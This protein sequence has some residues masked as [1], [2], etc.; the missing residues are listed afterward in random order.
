MLLDSTPTRNADSLG[1]IASEIE[2]CTRCP[3]LDAFLQESRAK[4]PDYWSRPVPGFG[5]P[6]ARLMMLGL[7]PGFHGA[8][9]HGR[10]FTGD[11]SGKWLFGALYD[12]GVS[13][14]PVSTGR[15]QPLRLD[16]VWISASA[17]CVPP[18]NKP[19]VEELETCRPFLA[20]ELALLPNLKVILALGRIGHDQ[21]L[22][23]LGLKLS[24]YPFAHGAVHELPEGPILMDTYHPSR[25]NTNTGVLTWEMWT[26]A[27]DSA[28]VRAKVERRFASQR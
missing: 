18:Q 27:I 28:L 3:R 2:T 7:A 4:F 16:G 11:D 5:D 24:R 25:Q 20:R 22:K 21:Y 1:Q 10:V 26:T 17:R 13:S 9:R 23:H 12:L 19:T 6:E 14:E 15:D 8:N